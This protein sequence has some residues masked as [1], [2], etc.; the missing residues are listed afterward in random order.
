MPIE[1]LVPTKPSD[2]EIFI[3]QVPTSQITKLDKLDESRDIVL[4]PRIQKQWKHVL[5]AHNH[6]KEK[7]NSLKSKKIHIGKLKND[8]LGFTKCDIAY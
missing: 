4:V 1:Y 2:I 5:W 7:K 3:I 6:Y 8:G